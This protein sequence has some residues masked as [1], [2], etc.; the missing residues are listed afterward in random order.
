MYSTCDNVDDLAVKLNDELGNITI[1]SED[2]L[3]E[4]TFNNPSSG[5]KCELSDFTAK[6]ERGLKTHKTRKHNTCDWCDFSCLE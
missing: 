1:G 3:L 2:N 4:S 5:L 6:S